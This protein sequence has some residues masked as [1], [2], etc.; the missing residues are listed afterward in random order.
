VPP[1]FLGLHPRLNPFGGAV[2]SYGFD[3]YL[4][5]NESTPPLFPNPQDNGAASSILTRP[6]FRSL[7]DASDAAK[8]TAAASKSPGLLTS[9]ELKSLFPPELNYRTRLGDLNASTEAMLAAQAAAASKQSF[10]QRLWQVCKDNP[11]AA[12]FWSIVVIAAISKAAK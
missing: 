6:R 4:G 8:D 9:D 12:I 7:L 2:G 10:F 3:R 11:V 5:K 1:A